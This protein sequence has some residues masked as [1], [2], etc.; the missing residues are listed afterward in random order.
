MAFD[1][2]SIVGTVAPVLG[3]ALGGPLGGM[4]VKAISDA[5]GLS[6]QTEQAIST[7][8]SGAKPEDLLRLKEADQRFAKDMKA[9]DV[10]LERIS[11]SDR[12]SA[13]KAS[14]SGGTSKDLL[15]LSVLLLLTCLG[16]EVAVLFFG[17]PVKVPEVV[18]GRILGLLDAVTMMVLAFW[19]GTTR[20]SQIKDATIGK[21]SGP[22]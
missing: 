9:L 8:L 22:S 11:A 6:E 17:Y 18:V 4:A 7:A 16:S 21:L 2:K 13:R 12:D 15:I 14:V 3:T 19:Y 20:G 10:D 5:L 1:W